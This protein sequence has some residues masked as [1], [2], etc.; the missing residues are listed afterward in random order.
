MAIKIG[1]DLTLFSK[2]K[3]AGDG[4]SS[5]DLARETG[6]E[7]FLIGRVLRLLASAHVV[8]EAAADRFLATDF[9]NDLPTPGF[10]GG[11]SSL[12]SSLWPVYTK[13]PEYLEKNA[14]RS[15]HDA[16][17]GPFQYAMQTDLS[18]AKWLQTHPEEGR[19]FNA[20]MRE[21]HKQPHSRWIDIYPP[22]ELTKDVGSNGSQR[23]G[24]LIVDVG[25]GIGRDM[26][27]LRKSLL[28]QKYDIVVQDL[29]QVVEQGKQLHPTLEFKEID[30]L[31]QQPI[32]GA[33]AYFM[34]SILHDWP[35]DKCRDILYNLAQA[36]KPGF[37]NL[38]LCE[39]VM[40]DKGIHSMAGA[41]DIVMMSFWSAQERTESDW[42]R[43]LES[44]QIRIIRIWRMHITHR[45]VI[46]AELQLSAD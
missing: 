31:E 3:K 29:P 32:G 11:F 4:K 40:P 43:L 45:A 19:A 7:A 10:V 30:F 42:T 44:R 1:L 25:G 20:L 33:R 27:N 26:E 12:F 36:F 6:G 39:N 14:Y 9:S 46:E 15:P 13:L 16:S 41:L 37:S 35:D 2:L 21:Y 8:K 24:P 5:E 23:S 28:P 18:R 17:N 22:S 38:L 34:Q